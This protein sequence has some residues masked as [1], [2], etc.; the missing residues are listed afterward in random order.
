VGKWYPRAAAVAR[1]VDFDP[2]SRKL[3]R[4]G[5]IGTFGLQGGG[6]QLQTKELS[7]DASH[8]YGFVAG[9]IYNVRSDDVIRNGGGAS[10]AH[11]DI[12]HAEVGH[13]FWEAIL[14]APDR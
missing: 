7:P 6:L 8:A 11:N 12:A 1:Q 5:A 3:P 9:H 13:V 2:T 14:A 4:Y 10:G